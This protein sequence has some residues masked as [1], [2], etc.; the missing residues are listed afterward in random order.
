MG[1]H[2]L[3]LEEHKTGLLIECGSE[4]AQ[5]NILTMDGWDFEGSLLKIV[6]TK[7]RMTG[8][9]IFQWLMNE[10]RTQ[11]EEN[12]Y[13]R[14]L[15]HALAEEKIISA[16]TQIPKIGSSSVPNWRQN[17][18]TRNSLPP[19]PP[20]KVSTWKGKGKGEGNVTSFPRNSNPSFVKSM[21]SPARDRSR[22]PLRQIPP[23]S[24]TKILEEVPKINPQAEKEGDG[25]GKELG[26]NTP[27][28]SKGQ[29]FRYECLTCKFAG[30]PCDHDYREC[31]WA[32]ASM[33]MWNRNKYMARLDQKRQEKEIAN[34]A[35]SSS[36]PQASGKGGVEPQ[37]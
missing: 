9:E 19:M 34:Q 16:P 24:P 35:S 13:S 6:P 15:V 11:E 17:V 14:G 30:Y 1:G 23:K 27:V 29:T 33:N 32:L 36:P 10:L 20:Q 28:N 21:G 18:Y 4:N 3:K 8:S 37:H 7:R 26:T 31:E 25:K 2:K 22:S 5:L 12:E